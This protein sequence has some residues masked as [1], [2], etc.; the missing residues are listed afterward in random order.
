[1]PL[2]DVQGHGVEYVVEGAGDEVVVLSSPTWWPLDPW[3]L[4]GFPELAAH[5][6][7]LAFNHRGIGCSAGTPT[8]Y[9]VDSMAEDLLALLDVLGVARAHV[10]GFAIGSVVAMVAA[11][12]DPAR[13]SSLVLAAAGAG[14]PAGATPA[15][16]DRVLREIRENGYRAHLRGH[17][18]APWAFGQETRTAHPERVARLADAMWEHAGSEEEFLKH[19]LARS[20]H[21][22]VDL[23]EGVTQPCL[24]LVGGDDHATRGTSTP[25]ETARV[26]AARLQHA[27]LEVVPGAGHLLFW[28]V[29]DRCWRRVLSFLAAATGSSERSGPSGR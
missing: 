29:P 2:I 5:Y 12:Q 10:V 3:R 15:V 17:V 9:T 8:T 11:R 16:P 20:G 25:L 23:A 22:T 19:A 26:L 24:V 28:D 4:S 21:A 18:A 27:E 1:M 7:V 13:I 6:R 14:Q